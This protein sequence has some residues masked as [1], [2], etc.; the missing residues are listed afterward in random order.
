VAMVC[1]F[2]IG[3]L[4]A[5]FGV[6]GFHLTTPLAV[7]WSRDIQTVEDLARAVA[8]SSQ[9]DRSGA[10]KEWS[11]DEIW[12]TLRQIVADMVAVDVSRVTSESRFVEDIG[13]G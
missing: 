13:A 2:F 6:V 11:G 9:N 12:T 8:S 3:P 1:I 7:V 10:K 4:A 5:F